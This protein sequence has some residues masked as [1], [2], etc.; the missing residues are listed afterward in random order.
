MRISYRQLTLLTLALAA[1]LATSPAFGSTVEPIFVP[2]NPSCSDLGYAF[3]FKPQPEPPPTGTYP[4]PGDVN[5]VA[6]TSDGTYFDWMSTL[7]ID[8]VIVKGGPNADSYVYDPP[9]ESFGDTGLHSPINPNT[10]NPYAISHIEF[11]YDYE[12][13]ATKTANAKYTRTYSWTITKDY[14]G[15]YSKFIGDPS[16]SHGYLVSVD[17]TV[18]DSAWAVTGNIII[19]NPTPFAVGFTVNDVVNGTAATVSCPTYT[20]AAGGSTICSYGASLS[21][22]VNGT[23]TA[24][25]TSSNTNVS[26]AGATAAY[27]FGDPTTIVG[28]PSINVTDTNGGSWTASADASWPYN[29]DF[30]CPTD[31]TLYVGGKY[32]F[33]H[34]NTAKITETGQSDDAKV[35]VNCY[36]PVP[37][38]DAKTAY[39]REYTWK[40]TKTVDPAEHSGYA[41][42]SFTSGYTVAVDQTVH[43]S[44]FA[45]SGTITVTNPHPTDA[46]TVSVADTV[47]STTAT[48]TCGGSLTV[49]A[50]GSNTCGYSADLTT[51]TDGTNTATVTLNGVGFV[52][53]AD[54]AFGDPTKVIGDETVNV[55]DTQ[56]DSSQPWQTSNDNSWYYK[57]D[58]ECPTDEGLYTDGVYTTS[59]PNK[60]EIVETEQTDD[61]NVNI[62]C[63]IP[64]KA[65]VIK[66]TMEGDEDIGQF[67]FEFEL[68]DPDGV[69]VESRTLGTGG[70]TIN[71]TTLV[72]DEGTWTVSEILPEGWFTDDEADCTFS[73]KY[74]AAADATFTCTFDNREASRVDLL[75]LTNGLYDESKKWTFTVYEGSDGFGGTAVA[76]QSTPTDPIDAGMLKFDDED[77]DPKAAY[78]VCE[79]GVAA[80]WSSEWWID[81]NGNQLVDTDDVVVLPYNPNADDD[82]PEDVG[83]RCVDIAPGTGIALV[84][85]T[86]LHFIV[87]NQAPGGAPRTPG[88]WK[89]W[90]RCTG[91]SQ[92]FTADANGGWQEGF[93]L[94]EDVLNPAVGGGIV[95]DDILSD[96]FEYRITSCAVA[97][98]ILDKRLVADPTKVADGKKAASDPLHNLAAHLLAAQLNFGAGA[99]T[100][101]EVL[102]AALAAEELLDRNNFDGTVL[103]PKKSPDGPEANALALYLDMYNNGMFC[104]DGVE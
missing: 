1:L 92:Q 83:N 102:D 87:D 26:G 57:G 25:I 22:A 43:E 51:K 56:P 27:A 78:T 42:D 97:V 44:E 89:N 35:T 30:A 17:Q 68:Y 76:S 104:G 18:T 98:D 103:L 45:V 59:V 36:A 58:F 93:W 65:K 67:P 2:G 10:N 23:N 16:T 29:K 75:K 79:L 21:G 63:Y 31:T 47:D 20:L 24:T 85:G 48:L 95:W 13:T 99:C 62:T 80:G 4:F 52:A 69:R 7:G 74:P 55:T 84:P 32:S 19:N 82:P 37:S 96:A 49:A 86:T 40:I 77:L 34:T 11:C 61:A 50:G 41:G 88:Y 53:T 71:V 66:K 39:T 38:K 60:A 3:G 81:I 54:Y 73:V 14:D 101:E 70:G 5:T 64:A 90:N 9:A 91:G 15:T 8:A 100:T 33:T 12:L 46:M 6:I 72:L 28:H 94:L